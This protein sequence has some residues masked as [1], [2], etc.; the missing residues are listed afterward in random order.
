VGENSE[1]QEVRLQGEIPEGE[2]EP[3]YD[4]L[5]GGKCFNTEYNRDLTFDQVMELYDDFVTL[6]EVIPGL[7]GD[8][9]PF[10][11]PATRLAP[12][13]LRMAFHDNAIDKDAQ[14]F[15]EYVAASIDDN[16]EWIGDLRNMPTSGADASVLMCIEERYHPNQNYQSTATKIVRAFQTPLFD[17]L[18][19]E[20]KWDLSYTDMLHNCAKAAGVWLARDTGGPS[21]VVD[22]EVIFR[23]FYPMT[24][25]RKDACYYKEGCVAEELEKFR[26]NNRMALC[27]PSEQL[28]G[29]TMKANDLN[30]W[31]RERGMN[32]CLWGALFGT[33][34]TMDTMRIDT[35]TVHMPHT[36]DSAD[37]FQ[38]EQ[39]MGTN[40]MYFDSSGELLDYMEYFWNRGEHDPLP[41]A[42]LGG[43]PCDWSEGHWPMTLIDCEIA[44]SNVGGISGLDKFRGVMGT[45]SDPNNGLGGVPG[46]WLNLM[47]C[48]LAVLGGDGDN[49]SGGRYQDCQLITSSNGPLNSCIGFATVPSQNLFGAY[50]DN[51]RVIQNTVDVNAPP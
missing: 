38:L 1:A 49:N 42:P 18:N 2:L 31:F 43:A 50:T 36:T 12:M 3:L 16:G 5:I 22:P 27:G 24:F 29:L 35:A 28:P 30:N 23:D 51:D 37:V 4:P 15:Q 13:C 44:S 32:E 33:H 40:E 45:M 48:G 26:V 41:D 19:L 11:P 8:A 9:S 34:T 6:F 47:H 39:R 7:E 14:E 20:Q 17:G 21:N 25:G 10:G 46:Y